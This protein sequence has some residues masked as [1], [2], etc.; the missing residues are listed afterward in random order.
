MIDRWTHQWLQ[1]PLQYIARRVQKYVTPDQLTVGGFVIGLCA[2]P[3][4]MLKLY[5]LA[6]GLILLNRILDGLDGSLAR[7]VGPSH[8]GGFLDITLDFVFYSAVILGFA[9]SDPAK[10]SLAATFLIFSFIGTGSSF[11]A[12][13]VMAEK[14][15]IER[16]QFANKSL[17]YLNGLT[18]GTETILFYIAICLWPTNFPALA[19]GFGVL[20]LI[21][22]ANRIY[23]GYRTI[24]SLAKMS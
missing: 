9:L 23:T 8:A 2:I 10:N 3:A 6:L 22:T 7:I 4:L 13:A 24:A 14:Y 15:N 11:L 18:E 17:Y 1:M 5:L 19:T 21:T 16:M 20:C 12:F